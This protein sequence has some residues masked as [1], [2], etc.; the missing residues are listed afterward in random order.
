[1]R[2]A[3]ISN[4]LSRYNR[5]HLS[6]VMAQ[7][8]TLGIEAHVIDAAMLATPALLDALLVQFADRGVDTLIVNGGDGT[9]DL[10]LTRLRV[11]AALASWCPAIILLRGGTTNMTHRDVGFGGDPVRALEKII[12]RN[13]AHWSITTRDLLC[14]SGGDL[15]SPHYGFFFGTHAIVRGIHHARSSWQ[16]RGITGVFGEA[17]MIGSAIVALLRGRVANHPLLAPTP[18]TLTLDGAVHAMPHIALILT[19]LDR[20]LLG[21]RLPAS[22]MPLRG[23]VIRPEGDGLLR[24]LP[25]LWRTHQTAWPGLTDPVPLRYWTGETLA[26]AMDGE[27]TLDGEIFRCRASAPLRMTVASPVRFLQ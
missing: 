15:P 4:A 26:L 16:R 27:V 13:D 22:T 8:A 25:T 9:L 24:R 21:I 18:I 20:L 1:M 7:A 14:L 19:T 17:A 6:A 5:E 23:I 11:V 3:L 12:T 10:V 2:L